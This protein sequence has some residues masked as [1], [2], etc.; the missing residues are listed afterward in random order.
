[1]LKTATERFA[2]LTTGEAAEVT[3]AEI[4]TILLDANDGSSTGYMIAL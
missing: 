4:Q 1:M 2:E 3:F